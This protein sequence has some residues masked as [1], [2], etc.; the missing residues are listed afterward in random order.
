ME[1]TLFKAETLVWFDKWFQDLLQVTKEI[2]KV[3]YEKENN[4]LDS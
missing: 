3:N 4:F 1:T 2:R